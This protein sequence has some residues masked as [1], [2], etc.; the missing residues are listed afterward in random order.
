MGDRDVRNKKEVKVV[1][2]H[3]NIPR[4]KIKNLGDV[5]DKNFWKRMKGVLVTTIN[6]SIIFNNVTPSEVYENLLNIGKFTK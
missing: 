5:W 3:E 2:L 6:Q 4:S 1:L